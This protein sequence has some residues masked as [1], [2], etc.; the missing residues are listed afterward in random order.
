VGSCGLDSA[1]SGYGPE[2]GS[3]END[4]EPSSVSE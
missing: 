3:Y 1:S 4:N 2:A